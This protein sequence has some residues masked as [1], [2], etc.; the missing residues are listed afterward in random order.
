MGQIPVL[1]VSQPSLQKRSRPV[2]TP[3]RSRDNHCLTSGGVHSANIPGSGASVPALGKG[4]LSRAWLVPPPGPPSPG[5]PPPGPPPHP[6]GSPK[7]RESLRTKPHAST[8]TVY[9]KY[10][11]GT[12]YGHV[13]NTGTPT[14]TAPLTQ[15]HQRPPPPTV[16]S[17]QATP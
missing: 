12:K 11:R 7:S 2:F 5:P 16:L 13:F 3:G 17:E 9:S 8:A 1:P 6:S 15:P 10:S 14:L 4:K